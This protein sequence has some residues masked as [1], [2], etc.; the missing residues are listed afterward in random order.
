VAVDPADGLAKEEWLAVA[1]AAGAADSARVLLAAPLT[2]EAVEAL[3]AG[4]IETKASVRF[5]E[6]TR[7]IVAEEV[8]ALGSIALGRRP[9]ERP[10]ADLV[11]AAL[12]DGVRRLGLGA[13]P[14]PEGAAALRGR[15][16]F[17]RA[18]GEELPDLSDAALL[19]TV[20]D[21]LPPV[22]VGKRRLEGVEPGTLM[23]AV[24]AMLDWPQRQRVEKLAPAR[25]ATPA[26]TS[27]A[28]DYAAEGGPAVE[29]RVQ[30]LFGLAEHPAVANGRVPLTL[31]LLSPAQRPIQTTKDLPGFWRGSWRAVQAEMK[32]RYPK[33]PWPDDPAAANATTRTKKA[34]ARR[35]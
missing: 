22:L 27:H 19:E 7:G 32:G 15:V 24:E 18:Q 1:E 9:I 31:V 13:L 14:W 23:G 28:I 6:A 8:R 30:E 4:E 21:W 3:F 16:A 26:G 20:D 34:D 35:T 12:V 25:M 5:D 33:H 29:V 17:L 2:R 10:G 11:T